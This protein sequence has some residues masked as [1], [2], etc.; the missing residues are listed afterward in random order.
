MVTQEDTRRGGDERR[1]ARAWTFL[2]VSTQFENVGDA[3]IVRELVRLAAERSH[4]VVD[5]SRCPPEFRS[6]L[7]L[8]AIRGVSV[9]NE[10]GT[11][12][13]IT[14]LVRKRLTRR[15]CYWFLVPGGRGG[16]VSRGRALKM[17]ASTL[18]LAA[19]RLIGTR[20]CHAGVSY[21]GLGPRHAR[22][23][24]WRSRLLHSHAVRDA[25]SHDHLRDLGIRVDAVVPD[26]ALNLFES[27]TP[28]HE[29]R[30]ALAISLRLDK[31][32]EQRAEL[33]W[34][35]GNIVDLATGVRKVKF[36]AQVRRDAPFMKELAAA[37]R[38]KVEAEYHMCHDD[39]EACLEVY[40]DCERIYS[41]RLHAL[42][43]AM[44]RGAVP[45]AVVHGERDVKIRGVLEDLGL[46]AAI[47]PLGEGEVEL[48]AIDPARVHEVAAA[49]VAVHRY[50]NELYTRDSR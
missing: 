26:L 29:R 28:P 32:P 16:E 46:D 24:R 12:R 25:R 4:T 31:Y 40:A 45:V 43:M 50:F 17:A 30:S 13:L 38:D 20:I 14:E 5:L 23:V 49:R 36:V 9:F 19:L 15:P 8:E 44:S 37:A 48:A 1:S 11:R 35:V 7:N 2:S 21:D 22:L 27:D 42:L 34:L 3:L 6:T 18:A 41:N 47:L 10:G 39:I 33:E